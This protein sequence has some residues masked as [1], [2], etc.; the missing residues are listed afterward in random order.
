MR[1]SPCWRPCPY[2]RVR[3]AR[4]PS[5]HSC[6]SAVPLVMLAGSGAVIAP[7]IVACAFQPCTLIGAPTMAG[8]LGSC[9][10]HVTTPPS[11]PD[12]AEVS[13][14][15]RL[16]TL[17][18]PGISC[19]VISSSGLLASMRRTDSR[20]ACTVRS[21]DAAAPSASSSPPSGSTKISTAGAVDASVTA[22][23]SSSTRSILLVGCDVLL[24]APSLCT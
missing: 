10:R 8:R 20:A 7:G 16:P 23:P 2:T 21:G 15:G 18:T 1:L 5:T 4:L 22:S 3:C 12:S 13:A 9:E 24:S 19:T 17:C 14:S 6:R 11:R